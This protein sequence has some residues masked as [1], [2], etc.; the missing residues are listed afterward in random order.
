M[1]HNAYMQ[2]FAHSKFCEQNK[3][4]KNLLNQN[5][6]KAYFSLNINLKRYKNKLHIA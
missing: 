2:Y 5:S 4:S 1:L 6:Y 3:A